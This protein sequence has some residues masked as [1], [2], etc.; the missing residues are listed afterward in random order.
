M[1]VEIKFYSIIERIRNYAWDK[2]GSNLK[3]HKDNVDFT[4]EF[5]RGMCHVTLSCSKL[6]KEITV[7]SE[8]LSSL[9]F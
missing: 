9:I 7:T 3:S 2:A 8:E 6:E 5:E 4:Y 1:G